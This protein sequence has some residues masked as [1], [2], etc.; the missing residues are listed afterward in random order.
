M[1]DRQNL[2][3]WLK[4]I[5]RLWNLA[6]TRSD[7][8]LKPF[9]SRFSFQSDPQ[10]KMQNDQDDAWIK[11]AALISSLI[12]LSI[13]FLVP[14][15]GTSE[16]LPPNTVRIEVAFSTPPPTSSVTELIPTEESS[17]ELVEPE[18]EIEIPQEEPEPPLKTEDFLPPQVSPQPLTPPK[19]LDS[20]PLDQ[21]SSTEE[22]IT[23]IQSLL[24]D[25]IEKVSS[26]KERDRWLILEVREPIRTS[27]ATLLGNGT[28]ITDAEGDGQFLISFWI[29]AEG[30]IYDLALK[31]APGV[32]IDA[33]AIRDA[34]ANLNPMTSAPEGVEAPLKIQLRVQSLE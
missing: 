31:P 2:F 3:S 11:S 12:H 21:L 6:V 26:D 19:N 24:D 17:P 7:A 14:V 16:T 32:Q 8:F 15:S 1:P 9:R 18:V 13:F 10:N 25:T 33:F 34:I 28:S 29:D 23:R 5:S 20:P 27:L 30:W 22:E 4:G